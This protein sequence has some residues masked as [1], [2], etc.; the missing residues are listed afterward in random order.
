MSAARK[1]GYVFTG[2]VGCAI[3][4][5]A[6][7][8]GLRETPQVLASQATER[9]VVAPVSMEK[10]ERRYQ[11]G[12]VLERSAPLELVAATSGVVTSLDLAAGQ[13]VE[14][15]QVLL[16]VNDSPLLAF[17]SSA[18]LYRELSDGDHGPDVVRLNRYLADMGLLASEDED[19]FDDATRDAL[20]E[21]FEAHGRAGVSSVQPADFVWVPEGFVVAEV[22]TRVGEPL[23]P[24]GL[25]ATGESVP[26]AVVVSEPA[27]VVP[28]DPGTLTVGGVRV[29]YVAGSGP[30]TDSERV[31]SIAAA[32]GMAVGEGATGELVV[33]MPMAV[34]VP[35]T[36]VLQS[37]GG[38]TCVLAGED[39]VPVAVEILGGAGAYV[40]VA[41]AGDLS[42]V[43]VNPATVPES[44]CVS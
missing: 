34:T 15:G 19:S 3:G 20:E 14:A 13:Q 25:L 42:S 27:E 24:G 23:T 36:A 38:G 40:R 10:W 8:I 33:P 9:T 11:V 35:T 44:Q 39:G 12:V 5:L 21:L 4:T 28:G 7:V 41:P 18:P 26:L 17:V 30:M 22:H 32:P 29:D 6:V 43:I 31:G 2:L 1:L 37:A 16:R